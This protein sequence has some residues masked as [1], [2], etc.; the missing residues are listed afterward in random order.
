MRFKK[1]RRRDIERN[2]IKARKG[3]MRRGGFREK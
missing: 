3:C 1:E 2:A